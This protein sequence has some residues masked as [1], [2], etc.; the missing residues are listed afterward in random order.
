MENYLLC[1]DWGTSVFRLQVIHIADFT[2][3]AQEVSPDGIATTFNSWKQQAGE[4]AVPKPEFFRRQLK[5]K[6]A[7]LANRASIPLD[8]VPMIISGMAS[9]SIGMEDVPYAQLPFALNGSRAS[10][11]YFDSQVDFP[12][13]VYLV[14]GVRSGE[15]VM[16][17][18]ETQL[19][20][21]TTLL[22]S[23]DRTLDDAIFICPGTHSKHMYVRQGQLVDFHTYMTGEVFSLLATHSILKNS[24]DVEQLTDSL[25]HSPDAFKRGLKDADSCAL[26][27]RIFTTRT[28][29]L[30]GKLNSQENALYLSGL[31][32]GSELKP[33]QK[34]TKQELVLCCGSSLYPFYTLA[35]AELGLADRT[36]IVPPELVDK[37]AIVG[38][39]ILFQN[40]RKKLNEVVK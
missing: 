15:D 24:V 6:I 18:E 37:A 19:I 32:I 16:R 28:N 35:I 30:F 27:N 34:K 2:V 10:V 23:T 7:G 20:G 12:H 36:T 14:S 5:T 8:H 40:H 31:L 29:Q 1:C 11:C 33:L 26:L 38:Q 22:R 39:V 21:V 4:D 17:G 9:S 13:E 3:L 25:E